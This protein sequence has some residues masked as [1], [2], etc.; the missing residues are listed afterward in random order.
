M[1]AEIAPGL[2]TY[3]FDAGI[4]NTTLNLLAEVSTLHCICAG[5]IC[6]S[7]HSKAVIVCVVAREFQAPKH[8]IRIPVN[9]TAVVSSSLDIPS[10]SS[11]LPCV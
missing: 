8:L 6:E 10:A 2:Q 7:I 1:F 5:R 11:L 3:E 9:I 4:E